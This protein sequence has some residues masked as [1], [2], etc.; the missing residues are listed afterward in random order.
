MRWSVCKVPAYQY[1]AFLSEMRETGNP[2]GRVSICPV[3]STTEKTIMRI[4]VFAPPPCSQ[5]GANFQP[6]SGPN[7]T[8][9]NLPKSRFC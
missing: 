2:T 1:E 4:E 5:C 6:F 3:D 7:A 8:V 9:R